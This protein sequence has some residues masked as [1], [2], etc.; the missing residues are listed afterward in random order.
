MGTKKLWTLKF[1]DIWKNGPLTKWTTIN[2][3]ADEKWTFL[4]VKHT[5]NCHIT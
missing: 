2:F 5:Y 4:I 1:M 3:R